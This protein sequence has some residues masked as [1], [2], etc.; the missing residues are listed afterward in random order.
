MLR[1][2]YFGISCV[3]HLYVQPAVLMCV[4]SLFILSTAFA[5][6][7]VKLPKQLQPPSKDPKAAAQ[8]HIHTRSVSFFAT[9]IHTL[10]FLRI[11]LFPILLYPSQV[12]LGWTMAWWEGC[13]L[14]GLLESG[15]LPKVTS[16]W[17][18]WGGDEGLWQCNGLV[19][20]W[21]EMLSRVL[22]SSWYYNLLLYHFWNLTLTWS[23]LGTL[24]V[25]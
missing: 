24:N 3:I 8:P 16:K 1:F 5:F 4:M 11:S 25:N 20:L 17:W 6:I 7:I 21:P 22:I 9:H 23:L 13:C 14:V 2:K 10:F 18:W 19:S 15:I 12:E